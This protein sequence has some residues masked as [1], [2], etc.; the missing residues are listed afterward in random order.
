MEEN[1]SGDLKV[2]TKSSR[3]NRES[4]QANDRNRVYDAYRENK[5]GV[6]IRS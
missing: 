6:M 4:M 3:N 2:F 1:K 5:E